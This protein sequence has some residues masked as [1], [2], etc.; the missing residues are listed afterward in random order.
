MQQANGGYYPSGQGC[1]QQQAPQYGN[2]QPSME[3]QGPASGYYQN[4]YA[5]G[6]TAQMTSQSYAPPTSPPPVASAQQY[7]APPQGPPPS[8]GAFVPQSKREGGAAV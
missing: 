8:N 6:N 4:Q 2:A 3:Q 1:Y 5:N 7:Y